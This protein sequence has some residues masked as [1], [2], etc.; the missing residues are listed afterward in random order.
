MTVHE[1][2][3]PPSPTPTTEVPSDVAEIAPEHPEPGSL[4]SAALQDALLGAWAEDRRTARA[5][6]RDPRLHRDPLL[7]MDEHRER[8]LGQLGVLLGAAVVFLFSG[9]AINAVTRAAGAI[10]FEV[11]R[12]FREISGIMDGSGKPEYGRCVDMLT[13]AA[14]KEMV[15]PSR[16]PVAVPVLVVLRV[17]ADYVPGWEKFGNFLAGEE[18][19]AI[20]DE[21]EEADT[22]PG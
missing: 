17:L 15:I 5:L 21:D 7:G 18:P 19:P 12:Q 22:A 2:L 16:L 4:D 8:V 1:K 10:V 13:K 14:I 11:R 9:L 20:E 3:A 6:V